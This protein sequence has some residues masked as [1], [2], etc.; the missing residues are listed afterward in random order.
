MK[1]SS[2]ETISTWER[3]K[4]RTGKETTRQGHSVTP[5][6]TRERPLGV[7]TGWSSGDL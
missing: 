5:V 6:V 2:E 3:A 1:G 7:G 4:T